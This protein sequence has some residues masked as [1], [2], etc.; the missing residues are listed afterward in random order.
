MSFPLS[1]HVS[2]SPTPLYLGFPSEFRF[3]FDFPKFLRDVDSWARDKLNFLSFFGYTAVGCELRFL[4]SP[5]N[6]G[7]LLQTFL[8]LLPELRT[9]AWKVV[10][11]SASAGNCK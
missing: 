5:S 1:A 4:L 6:A 2:A 3:G 11:Y 10:A 8:Y 9:D 7:S